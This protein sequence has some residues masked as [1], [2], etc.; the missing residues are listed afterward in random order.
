MYTAEDTA[1]AISIGATIMKKG[2]TVVL[3]VVCNFPPCLNYCQVNEHRA[4]CM[5]VPTGKLF[6]SQG[7]LNLQLGNYPLQI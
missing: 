2:L 1:Q 5:V 7:I 6:F 3:G 4:E